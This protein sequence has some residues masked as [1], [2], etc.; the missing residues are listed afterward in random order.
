VKKPCHLC[1]FDGGEP[2]WRGGQLRVVRVEDTPG[3]PAFYRVIWN[4]HVAEF[5]DLSP[6]ERQACMEAVVRVE[7][8]LR[9][10]LWPAKM[11][12]ASLGNMVPHLH[13]HVIPR[14]EGDAHFPYPVWAPAQ[15]T[16]DT[17]ELARLR[18]A[19][20]ELDCAVAAAMEGLQ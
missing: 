8:V 18:K 3:H 1:E 6:G 9:D 7:R 14:F 2:V 10:R 20:P 16:S 15:R 19:L 5:S 11:N 17:A 13:W 12:I 4:A